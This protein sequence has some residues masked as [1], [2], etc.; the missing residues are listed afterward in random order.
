[1]TKELQARLE[2]LSLGSQ[3]IAHWNLRLWELSQGRTRTVGVKQ[4]GFL[5]RWYHLDAPCN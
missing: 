3:W 5:H 4:Q 2:G 1:M